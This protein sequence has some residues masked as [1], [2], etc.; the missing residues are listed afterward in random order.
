M[1]RKL[2]RKYIS[3]TA[4]ALFA[5]ILLVLAAVNGIFFFQTDRQ[6][7]ERLDRIM[8][9]QPPQL[10]GFT[11]EEPPKEPDQSESHRTPKVFAPFGD[12]LRIH[13]DGCLLLLNADGEILEIR[14]DAAEN[15]SED[16]LTAIAAAIRSGRKDSGRYQYFKYRVEDCAIGEA[17]TAIGLI[18]ASMDLNAVFTMLVISVVIGIASL[19]LVLLVILFASKRA[20]KPIVESYEKQRQFVTDAGHELKTP[21]TV[22]SANSEL[23]RMLY[24]DSEWFDGIDRQVARMN[25]LVRSMIT[26]ARMDEEQKPDFAPF[27]LSDAVYDTAKSFEGLIHSQGKLITFDI[28]ENISYT[29]EESG[30]RQVVSILL[31]NAVKY[32]DEKGK[33]AVRL[34]PSGNRIRLQIINDYKN[35]QDCDLSRVFE[36][37]YRAD[38]ARTSDGS[39]GLG[40]SIA[41]S[42]VELHRG[43]IRAV[44]LAQERILFEVVLK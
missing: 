34:F 13:S 22:I 31:D 38:K 11:K 17:V 33:I 14:Q 35:A 42:V 44:S 1:I 2:Q 36:R 26:L 40:L 6:L 24:G 15:Y 9:T 29:G 19:S 43:E 16:E 4:A 12:R 21:L 32:C 25:R 39:Y 28:Q 30:I 18:N 10:N 5:M 8:E 7:N 41:K 3:I 27:D 20:I 37:F 23:A